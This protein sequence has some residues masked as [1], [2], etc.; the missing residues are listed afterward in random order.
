MHGPTPV[1]AQLIRRWV[2]AWLNCGSPSLALFTTSFAPRCFLA[3]G[4]NCRVMTLLRGGGEEEE[5][6][7]NWRVKMFRGPWIKKKIKI[8]Q[9]CGREDRRRRNR[10]LKNINDWFQ[11]VFFLSIPKLS[12]VHGC[13]CTNMSETQW[14]DVVAILSIKKWSLCCSVLPACTCVAFLHWCDFP[15]L[16]FLPYFS[17]AFSISQ[18]FSDAFAF[19][20]TQNIIVSNADIALLAATSFNPSRKW[21]LFKSPAT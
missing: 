2:S 6:K 15:F 13:S 1:W 14:G 11:V 20:I 4:A 12:Q 17:S 16:L 10:I 21:I 3:S 7:Q 18:L 8:R 5:D 19:T 9:H